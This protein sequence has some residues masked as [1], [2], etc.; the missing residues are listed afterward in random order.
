MKYSMLILTILGTSLLSV[1]AAE[2]YSCRDSNGRLHVADNQMNLP[3]ECHYQAET[4]DPKD[5]GKVNYVPATKQSGR[6]NND[7]NRAVN[8]EQREASQRKRNAERAVQEAERLANSY[9][10]AIL[11]RKDALRNK[12]YGF[13]NTV[14]QADEEM[15]SARQKKKLLIEELKQLRLTTTQQEQIETFLDKI[16]N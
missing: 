11:T 16:Q 8:Q 6:S 3:E 12:S 13:R 9:E 10:S 1:S 7:F 5:P 2:N 4:S 15:Q 14:I